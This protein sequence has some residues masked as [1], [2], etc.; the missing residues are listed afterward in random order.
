MNQLN[1]KNIIKYA[2][3]S[4]CL[5]SSSSLWGTLDEQLGDALERK[6]GDEV[7]RLT[8]L[9]AKLSSTDVEDFVASSEPVDD[10]GSIK[11]CLQAFVEK[12]GNLNDTIVM[13][14]VAQK[15][16]IDV[17]R[18]LVS[19][20]FQLDEFEVEQIRG[21]P[22][23][24]D[25]I[26][27]MNSGKSKEER[28]KALFEYTNN[29]NRDGM[30]DA[31]VLGADINARDE[32][33][34]TLLHVA[35]FTALGTYGFGSEFVKI[36]LTFDPEVNALNDKGQTPLDM[37]LEQY[38]RITK[39]NTEC[40]KRGEKIPEGNQMFYDNCTKTIDYMRKHGAMTSAELKKAPL[41][42][43][44]DEQQK[45]L[46]EQ[47]FKAVEGDSSWNQTTSGDEEKVLDAIAEGGNVNAQNEYGWT[48][49]HS[50]VSQGHLN[51]VQALLKY[52]SPTTEVNIQNNDGQTPL[53]IAL[54]SAKRT[55]RYKNSSNSTNR[56]SYERRQA[57]VDLLRKHNAKTNAE[58]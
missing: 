18:L 23:G 51:I 10:I 45:I 43:N 40:V 17:A 31:I 44:S 5:F 56:E 55:Q 41:Q 58:L 1:V 14:W 20:G 11:R 12:G 50:A 38:N 53:D 42:S 6:D 3:I 46:D 22:G 39:R 13:T 48:P 47:L 57:I 27:E 49:L 24:S 16:L 30:L 33:N 21:L 19:F 29:K 15:D 35:V 32:D 36:V 8:R 37:I 4:G 52:G 25:F 54:S 2:A 26:D 28:T 34:N 9:G 7:L